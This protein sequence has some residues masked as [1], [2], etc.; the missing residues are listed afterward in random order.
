[1]NTGDQSS[2]LKKASCDRVILNPITSTDVEFKFAEKLSEFRLG[3]K[4]DTVPFPNLLKGIE[5]FPENFT[6]SFVNGKS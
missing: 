5:P 4:A 3:L 6:N 1:M 2:K